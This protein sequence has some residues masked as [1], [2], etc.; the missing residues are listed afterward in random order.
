MV[1]TQVAEPPSRA[2]CVSGGNP[3]NRQ[4][5]CATRNSLK[6]IVNPFLG[7]LNFGSRAGA[8]LVLF[9][10]T[11]AFLPAQTFTTVFNFNDIDTDGSQPEAALVQASNGDLYGTTTVGGANG[12]GTVFKM[13]TNGTLTTLHSFCA[14]SG[15]PDG[16]FPYAGLVQAA[17]TDFYGTTGY[18][19][20]NN[21]GTVFKITPGGTLTTLYNFCSLSGCADGSLPEAALVQATNGDLYGTTTYGGANNGG[22]VF[23]ITPSGTFT[24]L[25]S[26]CAQS[27]CTDGQ[28]PQAPLVQATNGDLYGT[29]AGGGSPFCHPG[30]CGTVFKIT[31]SGTFTTVHLFCL[32]EGNCPDGTDPRAGLV[33]TS[34]GNLYGTTYVGGT[35]ELAQ[36]TAFRMT[37][38]GTL[39]TLYSF[40]NPCDGFSNPME[41]L[42]QATDGNLYGIAYATVFK[43]SLSGTVTAVGNLATTAYGALIQDTNGDL[44]GT[45]IQA[46]TYGYG[47]VFSLSEGLGPFVGTQTKAGKVG[48]EVKILGTDL[49]GATIV[50]F[51]GRRRPLPWFRLL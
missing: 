36:G 11:A 51:Q 41:G 9:A 44:Y 23:R 20:V 13:T 45:T 32:Q 6:R 49:T 17:N 26:F 37:P 3:A 34:D 33:Q 18:G 7:R 25:H 40:C 12:D 22:T 30:G 10:A 39:T 24:L 43:L 46:G 2:G 21:S 4:R 31:T 38:S 28:N 29:T 42:V 14:Q 19:G 16:Q 27:K 35:A 15:C 1:Q 47:T 8:V 48:A 50:S 5:F